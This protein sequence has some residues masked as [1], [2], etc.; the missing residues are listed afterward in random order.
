MKALQY[1]GPV[2]I[3]A[4]VDPYSPPLPANVTTDQALH[5]AESIA[6]GTPDRG[7][8]IKTILKEKARELV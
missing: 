3:E 1:D 7:K 6:K 5:F 4:V 8:I 2:L